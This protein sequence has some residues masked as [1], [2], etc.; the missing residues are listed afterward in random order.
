VHIGFR[1]SVAGFLAA[2]EGYYLPIDLPEKWLALVGFGCIKGR[3]ELA[4]KS[5]FRT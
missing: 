5:K 1:E 3:Y 4:Q 2:F